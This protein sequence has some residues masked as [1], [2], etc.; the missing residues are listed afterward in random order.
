MNYVKINKVESDIRDLYFK[1]KK[2][3]E[4]SK[5]YTGVFYG[6]EVQIV[7]EK[8]LKL[9]ED[10]QEYQNCLNEIEKI[11]VSYAKSFIEEFEKKLNE[12]S[13]ELA[14]KLNI[15]HYIIRQRIMKDLINFNNDIDNLTLDE[16]LDKI[17]DYL[18]IDEVNYD[19][20][21]GNN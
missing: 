20:F 2:R 17:D 19:Y 9:D 8:M 11:F 4:V 21:M 13:I 6:D 15:Y 14:K 16:T 5:Y 18:Y 3:F 7:K 10:S 12:V 1:V